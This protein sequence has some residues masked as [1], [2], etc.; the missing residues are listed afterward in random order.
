MEHTE[1]EALVLFSL[2][3][4]RR[5]EIV[6]LRWSHIDLDTKTLTVERTVVTTSTG[7]EDKKRTKTTGST[8]EL[9]LPERAVESLRRVR[10]R[11]LR[12][13]MASGTAWRG[14]ADGHVFFKPDGTRFA[15]ATA[16]RRWNR[17]VNA[18]GLPPLTLH[19]GRHT[20]ATL[21]LLQGAPLAVVAAWLGHANGDVTMRIYAHAQKEA[22]E[23]A[24]TTFDGL[25]GRPN[26]PGAKAE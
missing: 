14:E 11:Y 22:I 19:E 24:A 21:L 17:A 12:D 6:G 10:A 18:A 25:Y 7:T 13:R 8:R 4:M 20:A 1:D 9:P 16:D 15:P 2:L 26:N 3:G 23:A 5:S